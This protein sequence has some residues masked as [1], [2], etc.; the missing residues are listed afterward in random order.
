MSDNTMMTP[1]V[2]LSLPPSPPKPTEGCAVCAALAKQRAEAEARGNFS[3]AADCN[4]E[5]RNCPH[6]RATDRKNA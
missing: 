1:P 3:A 2:H 6:R 4:V 5:L